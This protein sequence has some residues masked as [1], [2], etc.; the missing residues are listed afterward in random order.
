M[1]PGVCSAALSLTLH[2]AEATRCGS[3]QARDHLQRLY[4]GAHTQCS[5]GLGA[6]PTTVSQPRDGPM[7]ALRRRRCWAGSARANQWDS[8]AFR[9]AAS[10]AG[11]LVPGVEPGWAQACTPATH[12]TVSRSLLACVEGKAPENRVSTFPAS[13]LP[14]SL[15]ATGRDLSCLVQ[16]TKPAD[17]QGI[18]LCPQFLFH[19]KGFLFLFVVGSQLA[20]CRVYSWLCIQGSWLAGPRCAKD[21]PCTR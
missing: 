10:D 4:L 2:T 15:E 17:M 19:L 6:P 12:Y 21:W 14:H 16:W 7:P 20:T 8:G 18:R 9:A 13:F 5:A 11:T 3:L 1:L